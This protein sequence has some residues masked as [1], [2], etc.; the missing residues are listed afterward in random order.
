[1]VVGCCSMSER[2]KVGAV[3]ARGF[4]TPFVGLGDTG[5][6]L[7]VLAEGRRVSGCAEDEEPFLSLTGRVGIWKTMEE[8]KGVRK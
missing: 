4:G 8:G 5:L 6:G 1:M 3:S 7:R 2:V